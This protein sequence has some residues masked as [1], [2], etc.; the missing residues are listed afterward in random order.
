VGGDLWL[1]CARRV[2]RNVWLHNLL[3]GWWSGS[4]LIATPLGISAS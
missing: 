3:L 1:D 2:S 4:G